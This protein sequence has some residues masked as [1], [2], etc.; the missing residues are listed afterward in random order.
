VSQ[1][2]QALLQSTQPCSSAHGQPGGQQGDKQR[3]HRDPERIDPNGLDQSQSVHQRASGIVVDETRASTLGRWRRA[4]RLSR[5]RLIG[6]AP[7]R[8]PILQAPIGHPSIAP[9]PIGLA[10]PAHTPIATRPIVQAAI[11]RATF[12]DTTLPESALVESTF[13]T[14]TLVA[15]AATVGPA[16]QQPEALLLQSTLTIIAR[17][18]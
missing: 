16:T 12:L 10:A 8:A 3:R 5:L 1:L 2:T 14:T 9:A 17:R 6:L 15:L 13:A 7:A 4:I 11:F 18:T